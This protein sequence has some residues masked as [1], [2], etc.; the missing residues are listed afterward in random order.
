LKDLWPKY[1]FRGPATLVCL[2]L[3]QLGP[4]AYQISLFDAD[5]RQQGTKFD[6]VVSS[7][8]KPLESLCAKD[9]V[10]VTTFYTARNYTDQFANLNFIINMKT[11]EDKDISES[12]QT[13]S[14]FTPAT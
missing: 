8:V 12:S 7:T 10:F 14:A 1:N 11:I 2:L 3:L 9:D 4:Y 13:V 6:G 5:R